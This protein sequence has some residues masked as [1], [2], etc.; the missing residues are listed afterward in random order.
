MKVWSKLSNGIKSYLNMAHPRRRGIYAVTGGTYMGEFFVYIEEDT[1]FI[2]L[3]LPDMAVRNIPKEK[4][5]FAIDNKILDPTGLLPR[6]IFNV[7][8]EQYRKN[9]DYQ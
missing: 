3:S 4:F 6:H 9:S 5:Q 1:D 7:C 8:L 2:F